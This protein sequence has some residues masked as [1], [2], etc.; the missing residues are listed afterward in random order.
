MMNNQ[1]E[2]F[3]SKMLSIDQKVAAEDAF[4]LAC[5]FRDVARLCAGKYPNSDIVTRKYI[6]PEI[7]NI[8]FSCELFIKSMLICEKTVYGK[9]H[10][11]HELFKLLSL[12]VQGE[13]IIEVTQ[14]LSIETGSFDEVLERNGNCFYEW[15]YYYELDVT[16][17]NIGFLRA[18]CDSLHPIAEKY[19]YSSVATN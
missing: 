3:E 12:L 18:L 8:A 17:A 9:N 5:S 14:K 4:L 11:L 7:V 10:K 19:M 2:L 13:V 16:P 6:I 15:R 1:K